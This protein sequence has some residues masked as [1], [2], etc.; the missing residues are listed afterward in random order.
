MNP[1]TAVWYAPLNVN[2]PPFNDVR[3]RQALN[4]AVDRDEL[5]TLFGGAQVLL[6]PSVKSYHRAFPGMSTAVYT[7]LIRARP[8]RRRT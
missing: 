5:V 1:L 3:V 2:L 6:R 8:G 4:Y 7:L